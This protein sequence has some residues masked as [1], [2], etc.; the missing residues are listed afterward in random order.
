MPRVREHNVTREFDYIIVGAG[1]AGCV[2]ANR[3][4]ADPDISVLLVE[5]GGSDAHPMIRM[6]RGLAKI[7]SNLTYIWPFMTKPEKWSNDVGESWARGRTLGGSSSI[8]GMVYVRGAAR[9]FDDL[10]AET[11]EDW[12]WTHIGEAY[13]Q[14]EAHEL[15]AGSDRGGDGPLRISL[16]EDRMELNEKII[17]A[18][19]AMGLQRMED[20]NDPQDRPRVGYAPRTIWNG[21]RQSAAVAFLRPVMNRANL[22]VETGFVV[23]NI[24]F[25]G[26]QAAGITGRRRGSEIAFDSKREVIVCAGAL[27]SPA[28]LQ[29]SG[30]GP[31]DLLEKLCIPLIADNPHVG[32]NLFEHRGVVFQWRVPDRL[33]QNRKFR[34]LGLM[35]SVIRYA[36][37]RNGAMAGGAYDMGAWVKSDPSADRPDIQILMAPF[38]FNFEA[39]PIAVEDY[40]GINFCVYPIRPKSRGQLKIVS[41][42]PEALPEIEPRYAGD[43]EDRAMIQKLFAIARD[44]VTRQPLAPLIEQETRPGDA[45]MTEDQIESAYLTYGYTNYHACGTCRMGNDNDAVLDPEL[46]VRG[47]KGLRVVDTSVFPFMLAGNTNAPAMAVAWRAADLILRD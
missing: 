5:S 14:M 16:P 18:G 36:L 44:Y 15:G 43:P 9:D 33:S 11:S 32:S 17:A 8:N 13:R 35:R 45:F 27:A 42:D 37:R 19:E 12:S 25:E 29:R 6:P 47:T 4:S 20:V 26:T 41:R 38:T 40:G 2:L 23:D 3:L 46:K 39:V 24:R 31:A 22:T 1:S 10:A 7:M 34:G 28:I 21:V 30:I